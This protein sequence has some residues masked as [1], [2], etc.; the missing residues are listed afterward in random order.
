MRRSRRRSF[1]VCLAALATASLAISDVRA[2]RGTRFK[3]DPGNTKYEAF[4]QIDQKNAGTLR[5]AWRH[6][7]VAPELQQKYPDLNVPRN[8][9]S[10]P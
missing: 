9:R 6:P 7:A 5:I 1:V 3:G 4:D 8:F 10:T 2:Q